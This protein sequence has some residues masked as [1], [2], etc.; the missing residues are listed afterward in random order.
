M[1]A[2]RGNTGK[3]KH[4]PVSKRVVLIGV[5]VC[6]IAKMYNKH[7][8]SSV[9]YMEVGM[10]VTVLCK[11]DGTFVTSSVEGGRLSKG[12]ESVFYFPL[13]SLLG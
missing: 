11:D 8:Q 1:K 4:Q 7:A 6:V 5:C 12:V 10:H 9:L 2:G 3:N 13:F